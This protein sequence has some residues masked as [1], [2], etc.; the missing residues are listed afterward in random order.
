MLILRKFFIFPLKYICRVKFKYNWRII[1]FLICKF[2][3]CLLRAIKILNRGGGLGT[4]FT[5]NKL[6][7]HVKTFYQCKLFGKSWL[8]IRCAGWQTFS[9]SAIFRFFA[10]RGFAKY[11]V[12]LQT[13][14]N[15]NAIILQNALLMS[16]GFFFNINGF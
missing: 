11:R 5:V 8:K 12:P 13:L 4:G 3:N 10:E 1:K 15:W 6:F 2:W 9:L 7:Q 14:E 16:H